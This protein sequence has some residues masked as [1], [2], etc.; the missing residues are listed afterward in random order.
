MGLPAGLR[1]DA[2]MC[3][4]KYRCAYLREYV[5]DRDAVLE[6]CD[7]DK[8]TVLMKMNQ[9]KP[10]ASNKPKLDAIVKEVAGIKDFIDKNVNVKTKNKKNRK[11]SQ[12]NKLLCIVE[13]KVLQDTFD[14]ID[15][16]CQDRHNAVQRYP[17][18]RWPDKRT[19][20]LARQVNC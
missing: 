11:S 1:V 18:M 7:T 8:H 17:P 16:T 5:S 14:F 19:N 9:D 2:V 4:F 15:A 3:T 6:E 13:S 10:K 12:M 20:A